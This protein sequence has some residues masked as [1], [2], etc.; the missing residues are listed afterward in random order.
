MSAFAFLAPL[1]RPERQLSQ[2]RRGQAAL[3]SNESDGKNHQSAMTDFSK[4]Q[5]GNV[6]IVPEEKYGRTTTEVKIPRVEERELASA[7]PPEVQR[8]QSSGRDAM[9]IIS[10][11]ISAVKNESQVVSEDLAFR[12]ALGDAAAHLYGNIELGGSATAIVGDHNGDFI[13]HI[14]YHAQANLTVLHTAHAIRTER[15]NEV[16][17]TE[18]TTIETI[19]RYQEGGP[20]AMRGTS[21]QTVIRWHRTDDLGVGVFGEVHKEE[22]SDDSG[23]PSCR[24]VKVLRRRQ[25]AMLGIDYKRELGTLMRLSQKD[26]SLFFV[27]FFTWYENNYNIFIAMEYVPGGDLSRHV[28]RRLSTPEITTIARQVLEGL[29]ILHRLDIVHR[30][31]K[32][33]VSHIDTKLANTDFPC[34]TSS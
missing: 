4:D 9:P 20:L 23:S 24:A 14:H 25:L 22:Q 13:Q 32:P 27:Q 30:D 31:I 6:S 5:S 19:T 21:S 16:L 3:A 8:L 33:A 2:A 12:R 28:K 34:R 1:S 7:G 29:C 26:Y 11:D 15:K 18:P 10:H 17:T